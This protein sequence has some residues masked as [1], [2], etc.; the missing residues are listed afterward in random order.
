MNRRLMVAVG[1][2]AALGL[3]TAGSVG[4]A[5]AA[6]KKNQIRI[7]GGVQVKLGKYVKDN[8][9]FQAPKGK[10]RSGATVKVVN[11]TTTED[12]HSI[13]FTTKKFLPGT[14]FNTAIFPLLGQA[15]GV[16]EDN[17]EGEPTIL[18]VDN[19]QP[20]AAG[21]TL[22]VDTPFTDTVMG[23]SA[24]LPTKDTFSFKVTAKKGTT[25]HYFCAVHPWMQG[26]LKV[27]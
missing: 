7:L 15:H 20:L 12:P 27:K 26:K 17:P 18:V 8:Q 24:F 6:P 9:R 5:A 21:A 3:F 1:A 19:G 25:L 11:K 2:T 13:S 10:V 16:P 23:D 4:T 14:D 22:N